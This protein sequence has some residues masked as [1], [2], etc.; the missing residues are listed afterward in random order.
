LILDVA[1]AVLLAGPLLGS[2]AAFLPG[3]RRGGPA[4]PLTLLLV[5]GATFVVVAH[6]VREGRASVALGGWQ[7]PLGIALDVGGPSAL[8]LVTQTVLF[9]AA[10]AYAWAFLR[11]QPNEAAGRGLFWPLWLVLLAGLNGLVLSRDLFNLYVFLEVAG[12]ASVGLVALAGK[13][14]GVAALRYLLVSLLGSM[15]YLLGVAL[16][17]AETGAVDLHGVGERL[18]DGGGA[19]AALVLATCGLLL[20]TA[21]WPLHFWLPP[22]H[23]RALPPISAVLS[24]LVV[25]GSFFVLFRL[26]HGAFIG[27]APEIFSEVLGMLG[28]GAIVWGSA[29]AI[30]QRRLKSLI[31]YSTVGQL[32]YLMLAFPLATGEGSAFAWQGALLFLTAH[33]AAKASLFMIAGCLVYAYKTDEILALRGAARA[34]PVSAFAFGLAGVALVGLPPSGG[35]LG[36]WLLLLVAIEEGRLLLA[37]VIVLGS[38]LAAIYVFSVLGRLLQDDEGED[39]A[40]RV[41][42]R[43]AALMEAAALLLALVALGLGLASSA[44][45]ALVAPEHLPGPPTGGSP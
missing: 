35:F 22:A 14:A 41:V 26:W 33:A 6:V 10:S 5:S 2:A 3:P 43:P 30:R 12:L 19:G 16:L 21:I 25:T 27:V 40:P 36:K 15:L 29:Q 37:T 39:E 8:L 38:L 31:A 45:L 13:E 20:K 4:V 11:A 9:I 1:L 18:T 34:L 7:P 28:V 32:G 24:S 23:A 17:Y 42:R 44:P